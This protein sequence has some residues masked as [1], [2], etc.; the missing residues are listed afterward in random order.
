MPARY[1]FQQFKREYPDSNACLAK[2]MELRYGSRP[3]CQECKRESK[4]HRIGKR[5]AYACQFCGAHLYPCVGTPFEKST[6]PLHHW[7]FAMYLFTT[8]RHGVAAKELERQLGVTY[9]CA[10]R[11]A[12]E[13]R[14]LM[15]DMPTGGLWGH[16]EA[17]ETYIGG[18]RKGKT[19][20]IGSGKTVVLGLKQ[21]QGAVQTHV[22]EDAKRRT[23]EPIIHREVRQ[24]SVIHTDEWAGYRM[25][26]RQG[27]GHQTVSH[28]TK[29]WV[30]NGSHTNNLEGYWAHIKRSIR[31]THIHVSKKYMPLYLAEF[32]FRHNA[33]TIPAQMFALLTHLLRPA[34]PASA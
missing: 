11:I 26:D 2:I 13:I 10:W 33:R 3:F 18:A 30:R 34:P 12:R 25:L 17:D 15:A 28:A 27:Y 16:V 32:N 6:T 8:T 24:G 22:V 14:R 9:K 1:T 5:R 7:F 19:G 20:G 31:G 23:L 21:R 4:F 29:E